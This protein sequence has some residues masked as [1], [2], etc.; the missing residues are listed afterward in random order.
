MKLF[1]RKHTQQSP[2]ASP[3]EIQERILD[4]L[5]MVYLT[6]QSTMIG[7]VNV[8]QRLRI[9]LYEL[10]HAIGSW[11]RPELAAKRAAIMAEAEQILSFVAK[12][13]LIK[14]DPYTREITFGQMAEHLLICLELQRNCAS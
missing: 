12:D 3:T 6:S 9:N 7:P 5:K 4:L 8:C 11:Q 1:G 10:H 13:C 14:D 2:A